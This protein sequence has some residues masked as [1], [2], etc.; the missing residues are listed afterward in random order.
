MDGPNRSSVARRVRAGVARVALV[1][2]IAVVGLLA[3]PGTASAAGKVDPVVDCYVAN[4][5]GSRTFVVGYTNNFKNG[6]QVPLGNKNALYPT[7]LHGQQPTTFQ[8]G[9]VHAAFTMTV[10]AAELRAG[11]GWVLD[12]SGVDFAAA[13]RT[14]SV[15]P[16]STELPEEGNGTGPAIALL[17]A[18]L[19]GGLAVR[20]ARQRALAATGTQARADHHDA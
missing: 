15:C 11:S 2:V 8:A 20:R 1:A 6:W 7:R 18:G 10:T 13:A 14:G 9:T 16:A 4:Q 17:G 3:A 12:G 19:V 5:D